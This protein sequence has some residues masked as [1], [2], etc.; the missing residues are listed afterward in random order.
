MKITKL[1][2]KKVRLSNKKNNK[3]KRKLMTKADNYMVWL[4][5]QTKNL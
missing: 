1:G 3:R 4:K 5:K 2:H